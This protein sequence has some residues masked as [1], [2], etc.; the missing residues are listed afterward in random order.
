LNLALALATLAMFVFAP[1]AAAQTTTPSTGPFVISVDSPT[2]PV[3]QNFTFS[4]V[5]V[6]CSSQAAATRVSVFD[7]PDGTGT[8]LGDATIDTSR[9]VSSHCPGVTTQLRAGFNY[10]LDSTRLTDGAHTLAF[11]ATFPSGDTAITTVNA[12][13]LANAPSGSQSSG[14]SYNSGYYGGGYYGGGY[15]G[16]YGG[17]PGAYGGYYPGAYPYYYPYYP[18]APYAPFYPGQRADSPR[19]GC[20]SYSLTYGGNVVP[21]G[22]YYGGYGYPSNIYVAC[23]YCTA[24]PTLYPR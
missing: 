14:Q 10:T 1:M 13:V 18:C 12:M 22:A 16:Y 23:Q 8:S 3:G 7:S 4:G 20:Q 5:A 24:Q 2:G 21:G 19:Y 15:G 11:V 6:D 9:S 17:Y